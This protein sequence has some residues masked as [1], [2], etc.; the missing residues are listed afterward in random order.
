M[1]DAE[2]RKSPDRSSEGAA[3]YT[4]PTLIR[5]PRRR[6]WWSVLHPPYTLLH[7]SLVVLGG[8]LRAPVNFVYL[9]VTVVAFFLGLGVGAHSLD[10]LHGRPLGT[11]IPRRQLWT[12]AI[13]GLGGAVALGAV[14]VIFVSDFLIVFMVIGLLVAI[15]YNLEIAHG[16]LHTSG[17]LIVGWGSFPVLTSYFAQHRNVSAAAVVLAGFAALLVLLQR[18]LSTPARLLRRRT[19]RVEARLLLHDGNEM[20]LTKAT[21]LAP[22]ETSLRILSWSG[23]VLALSMLLA[24]IAGA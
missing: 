11:T 16:R 24:R 7:L 4:S 9:A 13:V 22:L 15:G 5:H 17:V 3:Y 1:S 21:L 23:P 19:A 18:T 10:E 20:E 2:S 8:C 14:G 6:E 12:A